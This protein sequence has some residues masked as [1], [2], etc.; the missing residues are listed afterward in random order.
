METQSAALHLI[1]SLKPL[2][3]TNTHEKHFPQQPTPYKKIKKLHIKCNQ[4]K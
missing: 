2:S 3:D 4:E 1:S